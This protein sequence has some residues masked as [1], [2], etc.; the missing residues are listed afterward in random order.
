MTTDKEV[1]ATARDPENPDAP[2]RSKKVFKMSRSRADGS[3]YL[4]PLP[5]LG[6]AG[7][8]ISQHPSGEFH[9]KTT[10][11]G[12][13]VKIDLAGFIRAT[14][15]EQLDRI[16]SA[17]LKPPT[18]WR[19]ARVTVLLTSTLPQPNPA[20][21][22]EDVPFDDF[23]EKQIVIEVEDSADLGPLIRKLVTDGQLEP[24]DSLQTESANGENISMFRY[25]GFPA[26]KDLIPRVSRPGPLSQVEEAIGRTMKQFGGLFVTFSATDFERMKREMPEI[27][28]IADGI[29]RMMKSLGSEKDQEKMLEPFLKMFRPAAEKAA[30]KPRIKFESNGKPKLD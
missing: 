28:Q 22:R 18:G 10:D 8:H 16:L 27:G 19:P 11:P 30:S 29:E 3:V 4:V 14:F 24:G 17:M 7:L 26:E 21:R 23:L 5:G 20:V 12:L 1:R 15:L 9:L 6:P 25:V 13:E 2:P